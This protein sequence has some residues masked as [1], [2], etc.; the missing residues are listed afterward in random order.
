MKWGVGRLVAESW[1]RG[2]AP[3]VLPVWHEGL[4]RLLPNTEP[5]RLRLRKRL[6][7]AVGEPISLLPLLDRC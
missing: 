6:Y 7:L 3:L 2:R 4:D 5:Y 1:A